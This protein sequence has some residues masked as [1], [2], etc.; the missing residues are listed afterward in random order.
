MAPCK[1]VSDHGEEDGIVCHVGDDAADD[2]DQVGV[3]LLKGTVRQ[4]VLDDV[5]QQGVNFLPLQTHKQKCHDYH[6]H[7]FK[8]RALH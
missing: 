1:L 3:V 5:L 2:G 4:H 7:S 8:Q 6:Y